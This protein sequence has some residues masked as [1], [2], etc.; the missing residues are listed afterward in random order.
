[1]MPPAEPGSQ[2]P[3]ERRT[4]EVRRSA[5]RRSS[6]DARF[7][8]N[9]WVSDER[10]RGAD[11]QIA[12]SQLSELQERARAPRGSEEPLAES[13]LPPQGAAGGRD[14]R[15]PQR[16]GPPDT[17]VARRPRLE[18]APRPHGDAFGDLPS[19]PSKAHED[20]PLLDATIAWIGS[21]PATADAHRLTRP[22]TTGSAS[23][24]PRLAY[25]G[26]RRGAPCSRRP[27]PPPRCPTHETMWAEYLQT[28][29]P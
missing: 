25:R 8:V 9:A 22:S 4:S 29:G 5:A 26:A 23:H 15:G 2:L 3:K 7:E 28:I 1:M 16:G 6:K 13:R 20:S 18:E 21:P 24:V 14:R 12:E 11:R 17:R 10:E 19:L 27:Y